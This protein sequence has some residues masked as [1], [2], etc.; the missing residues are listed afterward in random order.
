ML[1][2]W[3]IEEF[4]SVFLPVFV[5]HFKQFLEIFF[6]TRIEARGVEWYTESLG[7]F[8]RHHHPHIIAVGT[9]FSSLWRMLDST[10][11]SEKITNIVC[12][13]DIGNILD[14]AD[15]DECLIAFVVLRF[16]L[17]VG[18]VPKTYDI[19]VIPQLDDRHSHIRP[20]T[21]VDEDFWFFIRLHEIELLVQD[22]FRYLSRQSR[23]DEFRI[24]LESRMDRRIF[25]D[26]TSNFG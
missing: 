12:S 25:W 23:N 26:D 5:P 9:L 10:N 8:R 11:S 7:E 20:T 6:G 14:L 21:D 2:K 19:I 1:A 4:D 17:D 3:D 16:W 24:F 22:I 18:V 13:F 15:S